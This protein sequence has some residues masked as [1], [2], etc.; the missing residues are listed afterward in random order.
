MRE[1]EMQ[2]PQPVD[3][4][5]LQLNPNNDAYWKSRGWDERPSDWLSRPERKAEAP[6]PA[7]NPRRS[8]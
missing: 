1:I 5:D 7:G 2:S 8:R 4:R 3:R 6:P